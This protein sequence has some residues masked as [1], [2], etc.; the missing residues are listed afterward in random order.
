[1]RA[2]P[3]LAH[4]ETNLNEDASQLWRDAPEFY[5]AFLLI[6]DSVKGALCLWDRESLARR[7]EFA[8]THGGAASEDAVDWPAAETRLNGVL[9][10]YGE[11][12]DSVRRQYDE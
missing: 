5:V 11:S 2:M 4:F 8:I 6:P 3:W 7:L 10:E 9:T 1:M 12:L